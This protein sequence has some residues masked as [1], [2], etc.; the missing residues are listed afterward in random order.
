MAD[1]LAEAEADRQRLRQQLEE[2]QG[3]LKR[4]L[5]EKDFIEDKFME[6]D[7]S[8][9]GAEARDQTLVEV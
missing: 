8:Q 3:N 2:I 1:Q 4:T 9:G 6:L 7:A 5:T